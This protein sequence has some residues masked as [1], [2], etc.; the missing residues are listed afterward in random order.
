MI[1]TLHYQSGEMIITEN[2][3]GETAYIIE[4]GKVRIAKKAEGRSIH[5]CDLGV[6]D[7]FGEMGMID[8]RPR[9]ASVQA[10]EPTTVQQIHRDSFFAGIQNEHELPLKILVILFERLRKADLEI[11]RLKSGNLPPTDLEQPPDPPPAPTHDNFGHPELAVTLVGKTRLARKKLP[12]NPLKI[13]KLPFLIGRITRDPFAYNDLAIEDKAPY[14]ISRHH[15]ELAR[16]AEGIE[17]M[18][19]GSHLGS[20]VNGQRMGGVDGDPSPM[21]IAGPKAE[22]ILGDKSSPYKYR[23]EISGP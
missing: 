13:W 16:H 1:A 21:I 22:L 23:I 18:D 17:L 10:L 6:G 8:E 19:R 20:I 9:S 11:A 3:M 2:E 5:I 7:I 4:K 12:E 14:R 15:L